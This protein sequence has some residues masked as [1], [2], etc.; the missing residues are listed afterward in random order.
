MVLLLTNWSDAWLM[1]GIGIGVVFCILCILVLVL[2]VFNL[3][4]KKSSS[5]AD[6]VKAGIADVPAAKS[7]A[8]ASELDKAAVATAIY[9]YQKSKG[10]QESGVLTIK[11]APSAWHAVLNERL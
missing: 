7:V 5:N 8:E 11:N 3:V 10:D 1:T 9:L 4:A 2:Q 6:K